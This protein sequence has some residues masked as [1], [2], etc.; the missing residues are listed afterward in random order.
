MPMFRHPEAYFE[1][2]HTYRRIP[3]LGYTRACLAL[4]LGQR[5]GWGAVD[6][7]SLA[8]LEHVFSY[9]VPLGQSPEVKGMTIREL[10]ASPRAIV[11]VPLAAGALGVPTGLA[12]AA[13]TG[14]WT[15]AVLTPVVTGGSAIVLAGSLWLADLLSGGVKHLLA[16]PSKPRPERRP[17]KP[18]PGNDG[19]P[20]GDATG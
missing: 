7:S 14:S 3:A 20:S 4:E 8:E 15:V 6:E 17:P 12:A 19:A 9:E 11:L 16:P 1:W 18:E 5:I 10:V 13:I 2:M